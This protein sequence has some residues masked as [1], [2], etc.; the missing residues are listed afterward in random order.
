MKALI[1]STLIL[2]TTTSAY[3]QTK[4]ESCSD[5]EATAMYMMSMRLKEY[6]ISD[7]FKECHGIAKCEAFAIEAFR[8]DLRS[9]SRVDFGAKA[10]TD[11]LMSTEVYD[12]T[13]LKPIR[14]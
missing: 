13:T 10:F 4:V 14:D 5:L 9:V 1:L 11:C 12:T 6:Q 3:S 2:L 8:L 7:V